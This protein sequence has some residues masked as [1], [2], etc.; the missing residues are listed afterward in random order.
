MQ[1]PAV[2]RL[3]VWSCCPDS[4]RGNHPA[5]TAYAQGTRTSR[6]HA[7]PAQDEV[8]GSQHNK[9]HPTFARCSLELLPGFGP[10]TS[11]LPIIGYAVVTCSVLSYQIVK[12]SVFTGLSGLLPCVTCCNVFSLHVYTFRVYVYTSVYT[13]A[14]RVL[15]VPLVSFVPGS[16]C[17][18]D[19]LTRAAY[20]FLI[21][22]SVHP[23][24]DRR[25][26]VAEPLADGDDIRAVCNSKARGGVPLRYNYD[27]PEKPRISRVFGYLARFFI[28]FQTEKSSREVV[29][30]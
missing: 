21:G 5:H 16:E 30:S 6:L 3:R 13:F 7:P 23:Q 10:G 28:L 17:V 29:I 18:A 20:A 2:F 22:V 19:C 4:D 12:N 11:S 8:P 25:V 24:R 26:T 14:A 1:R 15:H 27:K 9:K